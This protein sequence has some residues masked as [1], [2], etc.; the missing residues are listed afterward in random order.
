[1]YMDIDR[2]LA[3][4]IEERELIDRAISHL[5]RLSLAISGRTPARLTGRNNPGD[6]KPGPVQGSR[7][8]VD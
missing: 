2:V 5:E 3:E 1:M 4:L 7:A 8:S 6:R